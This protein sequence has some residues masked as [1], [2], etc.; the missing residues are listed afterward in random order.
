[1]QAEYHLQVIKK[2]DEC[3]ARASRAFNCVFPVPTLEWK[4]MGRLAGY[5]TYATHNIKLSP[6]LFGQNPEKFLNV[7]VPHELAHLLTKILYPKAKQHHGPEFRKV[8]RALGMT[9][10]STYHQ[11]DVSSVAR[12]QVFRYVCS[13][14]KFQFG[15][16]RHERAQKGRGYTCLRCKKNIVWIEEKPLQVQSSL[17]Q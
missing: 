12:G 8:C 6:T 14:R 7:T 4:D 13:C 9:D 1:M 5:A 2:L 3:L 10:V 17:I 11:Y 16:V 15:K